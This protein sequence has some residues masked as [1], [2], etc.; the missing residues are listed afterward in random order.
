MISFVWSADCS[1]S[2]GTGGS[3]SYTVGHIRELRRRGIPARLISLC[4]EDKD[5][6]IPDVDLITLDS[7]E[8][9]QTLDDTLVFITYPLDV[10]TKRPSYAILHCPLSA[11]PDEYPLFDPAGLQHKQLITPSRFASRLWSRSIHAK[12]DH[13]PVAYPF[14]EPAFS[15]VSRPEQRPNDNTTRIL[16][17]GRLTPDKGIY[18]LLAALHMASL[19]NLDYHITATD[20][21]IETDKGKIIHELLRVHPKISVV[22]ARHSP[23]AMAEL[24]AEHDIVVMPSTDIFWH[25]IFGMVSVEAQ[26]AGCRVVASNAGGLP[27]TDCGGMVLVKPDDPLAL[28]NGLLKAAILGPLTAAERLYACTQFSVQQSVDS[29]LR[30]MK[31]A[32]RRHELPVPLLQKQGALVREQLDLAVNTI[33][34]LGMRFAREK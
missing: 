33:S 34:Q 16:F 22:P 29:L 9:L 11:C 18:T 23:Q 15:K 17:A 14:A 12:A 21:G 13:I 5:A 26:H 31:V 25:E 20:A 1:F 10:P 6:H 7:P 28:A 27:E 2:G 24:M 4:S 3:E 32:E 30:I 8:A 19:Q